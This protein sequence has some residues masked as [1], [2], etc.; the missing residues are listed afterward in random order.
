AKM[1]RDPHA[2]PTDEYLITVF[3]STQSAVRFAAERLGFQW[4]PITT[5]DS[6]VYVIHDGAVWNSAEKFG[7]R[8]RLSSF[9]E[10]GGRGGH[11]RGGWNGNVFSPASSNPYGDDYEDLVDCTAGTSSQSS[12]SKYADRVKLRE[13]QYG[14]T[15]VHNDDT[16]RKETK[17]IRKARAKAERNVKSKASLWNTK[18]AEPFPFSVKLIESV[19]RV[20]EPKQIN[21]VIQTLPHAIC[22]HCNCKMTTHIWGWCADNHRSHCHI[23]S[24]ESC[25]EKETGAKVCRDC[26]C[27]LVEGIHE[28]HETVV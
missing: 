15:T 22:G 26:G 16:L 5:D 8:N 4:Y 25:Y 14:V 20:F 28:I 18:T 9:S 21:G 3:A 17:R 10:C 7:M 6:K 19:K 13:S 11:N 23:R 2:S 24:N 1:Y 12:L 27:Y